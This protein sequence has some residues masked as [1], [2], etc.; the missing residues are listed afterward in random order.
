MQPWASGPA[1]GRKGLKLSKAASLFAFSSASDSLGPE[2]NLLHWVDGGG[3]V[4]GAVGVPLLS[5]AFTFSPLWE[6]I[7]LS[8]LWSV[9]LENIL[10]ELKPTDRSTGKKKKRREGKGRE[11]KGREGKGREG[12]GRE[13]KGREEKRRE[14]KRREEKRREEKRREEKKKKKR[15]ESGKSF[16]FLETLGGVGCGCV[17]EFVV[18]VGSVLA[19]LQ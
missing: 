7:A 14:E 6:R 8:P 2:L 9:G 18:S 11:G 10:Q 1:R 5:K 17:W 19:C 15:K 3:K 4:E 16:S 12:K 13:G